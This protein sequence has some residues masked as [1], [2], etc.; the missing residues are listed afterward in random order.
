MKLTVVLTSA[1]MF[2]ALAVSTAFASAVRLPAQCLS[3]AKIVCI[4]K[5]DR[6]VRLVENG[7][8]VLVMDA[9]FGD[10]RGFKYRTYEGL[11][12]IH[13]KEINSWSQPFK[14]WMPYAMYF[15]GHDQAIHYSYSFASEGY[16]GA[17]H[18]CVNTRDMTKLKQLF[19]AVV[20]DL[21]NQP[22]TGTL[23]YIY[24]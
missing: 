2:V 4:S 1:M 16:T 21:P 10:A 18:G 14:V 20:A 8:I 22:G 3:T 13:Y 17:S 5:T 9:R 15:Y 23:V 19:N 7:R 12:T 11:S 24:R 6:K